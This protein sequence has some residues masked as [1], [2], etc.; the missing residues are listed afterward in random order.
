VLM[1]ICRWSVSTNVF[2]AVCLRSLAFESRTKYFVARQQ[3]KAN[4]LL[5]FHG[6]TLLFYIVDSYL[7][8]KDKKGMRYYFF[9]MKLSISLYC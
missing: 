1:A 8:G 2:M 6:K 5:C 3:C 7:L 9:M 4:Q